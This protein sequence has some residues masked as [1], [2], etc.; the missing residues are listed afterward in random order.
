MKKPRGDA[1][2]GPP[3]IVAAAGKGRR[4]DASKPQCEVDMRPAWPARAIGRIC[5]TADSPTSV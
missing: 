5:Q 3:G 2:P 4:D 1:R